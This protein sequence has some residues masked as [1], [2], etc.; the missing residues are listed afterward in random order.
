[1]N[2]R[3]LDW[4]TLNAYVDG[5]LD[6]HAAAVVAE[7]AGNDPAVAED[8]ATLYRL[9]AIVHDGF[10]AAPPCLVAGLPR[11]ARRDRSPTRI[12]TVVAM[13]AMVMIAVLFGPRS[14]PS[15]LPDDVLE[16]A[17]AL[18]AEWLDARVGEPDDASPTL[19]AALG[20][21]RQVPVIPDLESARL[22][23]TRVRL[24]EPAGAPVLQVGYRGVHDC[25]LSLLVFASAE[26]P[27][28]MARVD[29]GLERAYGWRVNDL[30]YMLF[31]RGMDK[32]ML[33]LIAHKVEEE[34]RTRAPFDE[35]TRDLIS[36]RKRQST[37]CVA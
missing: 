32:Q 18:H 31:A 33:D 27:E 29:I 6:P 14:A 20:H 26:M 30:G 36:A 24:A 28:T 13:A 7:A 1:M 15:V 11:I 4:S 21:F 25:H 10:P 16:T 23:I 35:G 3:S 19:M 22:T 17:R 37:S 2:M 12:A 34:T 8:I 5:E 9:K